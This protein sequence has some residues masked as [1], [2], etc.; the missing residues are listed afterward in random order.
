MEGKR[1]VVPLS[2]FPN[3]NSIANRKKDLEDVSEI[4]HADAVSD[5]IYSL[6]VRKDHNRMI[7]QPDNMNIG[8]NYKVKKLNRRELRALRDIERIK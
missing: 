1:K 5:R 4:T 7:Y 6:E 8:G 3:P 2:K